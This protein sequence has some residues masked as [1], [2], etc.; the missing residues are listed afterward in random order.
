MKKNEVLDLETG[1]SSGQKRQRYSSESSVEDE[2]DGETI[3]NEKFRQGQNLDSLGM[4]W[5]NNSE[6][7]VDPPDDVN[8]VEWNMLG[9][10]L[11]K[12]FLED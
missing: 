10:A 1:T 4:E 11:E 6:N 7:S 5:G 9:A 12:E 2:K 3:I 8:D